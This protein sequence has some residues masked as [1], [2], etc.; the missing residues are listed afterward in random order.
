MGSIE[1]IDVVLYI[2]CGALGASFGMI[3]TAW[4]VTKRLS[5]GQDIREHGSGNVGAHN[6]IDVTGSKAAGVLV[7]LV[8]VAK[9]FIPVLVSTWIVPDDFMYAAAAGFFAVALHNYN[10]LLKGKGG[11]GLATAAGVF[12]A[13]CPVA[14]LFWLIMFV[15]GRAAI[16][17]NVN[18]ASVIATLGMATLLFGTPVSAEAFNDFLL[19]MMWLV[20]ANFSSQLKMFVVVI[21]ILVIL[22]HI[23]PIRELMVKKRESE[24]SND[25]EAENV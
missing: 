6:T 19:D 24:M 14:V 10:P 18:V 7:A 11:R 1:F 2:V 25:P 12:L 20:R 15:T 16:S 4:I 9:G 22:K 8:D 21:S 17:K 23:E 5:H 13:I 3:P